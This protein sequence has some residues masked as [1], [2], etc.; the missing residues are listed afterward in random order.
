M[1][2]VP[3]D[4]AILLLKD[5]KERGLWLGIGVFIRKDSSEEHKFWARVADV[6]PEKIV[7]AG[8][9]ALLEIPLDAETLV[10]YAEVLEAPAELRER[11]SQ[12]EFCLSIRSQ[13][14]LALLFGERPKKD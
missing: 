6:S 1:I 13:S 8:V 4:E 14:V 12:Y 2:R 10:E 11:F 5:W 7:V 9:H 3:S